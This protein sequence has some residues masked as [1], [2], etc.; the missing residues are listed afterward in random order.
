MACFLI[1]L[2]RL[3]LLIKIKQKENSVQE[4]FISIPATLSVFQPGSCL[5]GTN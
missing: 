4:I 1:Y 3:V 5:L 2:I